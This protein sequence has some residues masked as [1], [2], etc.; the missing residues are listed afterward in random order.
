MPQDDYVLL[1]RKARVGFATAIANVISQVDHKN[2][3][4]DRRSDWILAEIHDRLEGLIE[5]EEMLTPIDVANMREVYRSVL[6]AYQVIQKA[7][8]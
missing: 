5:T 4:T 3:A 1:S 6:E 7:L 8:Q 2:P